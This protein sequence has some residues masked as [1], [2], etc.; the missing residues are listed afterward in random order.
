DVVVEAGANIGA[1]TLPIAK[2]VGFGGHIHAFEPQRPIHAMLRV[3]LALNG[4]SN[5]TAHRTGLGAVPGELRLPRVEYARPGNFGAYGLS[6]EADG[7]IVPVLTVDGLE[8]S[9][10]DLLKID[11]Q[12]MELAV[13]QGA[14]ATIARCRP[15]LYVEND[16]KER[17]AELLG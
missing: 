3:N 9:R 14:A 5:V 13:L 6:A 15:M 16:Q 8:L 4:L 17:S 2:R 1:L 7:E 11:V 10:C 12:G